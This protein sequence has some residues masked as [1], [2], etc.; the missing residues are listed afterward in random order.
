MIEETWFPRVLRIFFT[1]IAIVSVVQ[2]LA[3]IFNVG[4]VKGGQVEIRVA[5]V[6]KEIEAFGFFD[7]A[8]LASSLLAAILLWIGVVR[9]GESRLSGYK[10]I[11]RSL[12]V[13]ICLTQVFVF[14]QSQFAA[15][16]GL[17]ILLILLVTVRAMMRAELKLA[18][19]KRTP[20]H[21][22]EPLAVLRLPT[23]R[24]PAHA[25]DP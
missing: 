25:S 3:L 5:D 17:A 9:F 22:E 1:L 11:E 12:L 10:W 19:Q 21:I 23:G 20:E 4:I 16:F 6:G 24:S 15:V 2:V 7:W 13:S 14:I 18:E 8:N